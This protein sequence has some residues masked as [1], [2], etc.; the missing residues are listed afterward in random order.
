MNGSIGWQASPRSV[1]R[2]RDQCSSGARSKSAQTNVSSTHSRIRRIC[3]CQ[4]SYAAIASETSPR[5]VD[6]SRVHVSCSM[7]ATKF[8]EPPLLDVVV[9]EVP[10]G[11]H[12]DLGLDR[13]LELGHPIGRNQTAV[14]DALR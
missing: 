13:D 9:D 7:S 14:G 11:A 1:T 12:P 3:G 2:P 5:L 8:N 4:P 6:D 10:P